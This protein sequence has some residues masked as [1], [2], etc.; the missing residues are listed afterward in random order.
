MDSPPKKSA[1]QSRIRCFSENVEDETVASGSGAKV[2]ATMIAVDSHPTNG[3]GD[4]TNH[5]LYN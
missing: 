3:D 5:D 4:S 2:A 1:I